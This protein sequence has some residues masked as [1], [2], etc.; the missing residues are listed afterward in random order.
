MNK[1]SRIANGDLLWFL[2]AGDVFAGPGVLELVV[3]DWQRRGWRWAYGAA[4][5]LSDD[6]SV[7]GVNAPI[8]FR[9][10]RFSLG[11][12]VLPH[13]A[14]CFEV[15]LLKSS[16]AMTKTLVWQPISCSCCALRFYVRLRQSRTSSAISMSVAPALR[17]RLSSTSMTLLERASA[18]AHSS[19]VELG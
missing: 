12:T 13:Q 19:E 16:E 1:G 5:L 9:L 11:E 17:G 2:H 14:A 4:R 18:P 15:S 3:R 10:R 7:V 6:G 8:P